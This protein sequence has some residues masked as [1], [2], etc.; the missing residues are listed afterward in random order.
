ML[1]G[2]SL[3][4]IL[5]VEELDLEFSPNLNILS[6]ETGAGKSFLLDSLGFALGFESPKEF[7]GNDRKSGEV[8]VCFEVS[9]SNLIGSFLKEKGY[10]S[11]SEIFIK[12]TLSPG[13]RSVSF[14]NNSRC[15][16]DFLKEIAFFLINIHG[17][18]DTSQL[19][20]K[21]FHKDLLDKFGRHEKIIQDVQEKWACFQTHTKAYQELDKHIKVLSRDQEFIEH[22][23]NEFR[24]FDLEENE[25]QSLESKR[26]GMKFAS[27]NR[28]AIEIVEQ[29]I[30]SDGITKMAIEA[31]N[32][33]GKIRGG[34]EEEVRN[35]QDSLERALMEVEEAERSVDEF[36][37]KMDF[38]PFELE[39]LENRLFAIRALARKHNV[40]PDDLYNYWKSMENKGSELIE[41]KQKLQDLDKARNTSY[42]SYL[43]KVSVLSKVR[44]EAA[45]KLDKQIRAE[46]PPLKLENAVFQ[47]SVEEGQEGPSGKDSIQFLAST[48]PGVP[49]GP[50]NKIASGG[51]LSRF[52]L[53]LKVC[54]TNMDTDVSM[55]FDEIDSGIGGATADAVGKKLMDLSK[56]SQV[57]AITHSPQVAAL[58]SHHFKIEKRV[59]DQNTS[60]SVELL[61]REKRV[62]EIARML[63]AETITDEAKSAAKVLLRNLKS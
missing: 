18:H 26:T 7:P 50:I 55:V 37:R 62:N 61:N 60:I 14:V 2:I 44:H 29:K 43:K 51:E 41:E 30:G 3:R 16:S 34:S 52:L 58:G 11:G 4:N 25:H 22:S 47:T 56:N 35:V 5:F 32:A 21:R 53:A 19:L 6:G 28:E 31:I 45:Q 33:I 24:D 49:I 36:K 46:L 23:L 1:K 15:S 9:E 10:N 12:R 42:A 57:V 40:Q 20:N 54:L 39:N 38:D 13:G 48:N 63:A 27:R 8:S 59:K 17:Q